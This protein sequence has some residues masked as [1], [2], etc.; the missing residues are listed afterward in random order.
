MAG[1]A[2]KNDLADI[3]KAKTFEELRNIAFRILDRMPWPIGIVC[4]PLTTGGLGSFELNMARMRNTISGLICCDEA[5]FN[6]LIFEKAIHRI[7][8]NKSY[9]K[10]GNHLLETFYLP[11]FKKYIR[12]IYFIPGWESSIGASWEHKRAEEFDI[13]IIHL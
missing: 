10:D 6:Q 11:I 3:A 5:V 7:T 1:Y 4:G 12:V 8:D 2:T 9:Y 13:K